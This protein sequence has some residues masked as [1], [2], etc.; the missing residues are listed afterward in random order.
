MIVIPV[1]LAKQINGK[2]E[3]NTM[4]IKQSD[5][6]KKL[7]NEYTR[8]LEELSNT[9]GTDLSLKIRLG[10]IKDE[11]KKYQL[12]KDLERERDVF[13][14]VITNMAKAMARMCSNGDLDKVPC[15]RGCEW[16][17]FVPD[18]RTAWV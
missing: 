1:S 2:K 12:I 16:C 8:I 11:I 15:G 17:P 10:E 7:K 5:K 3:D 18:R 9:E 14:D 4:Q 13:V 6:I